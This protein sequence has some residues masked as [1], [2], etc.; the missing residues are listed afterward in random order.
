MDSEDGP[1]NFLIYKDNREVPYHTKIAFIAHDFRKWGYTV[2]EYFKSAGYLEEEKERGADLDPMARPLLLEVWAE[3]VITGKTV[4]HNRN[5]EMEVTDHHARLDRASKLMRDFV[6][7]LATLGE[8]VSPEVVYTPA[9]DA[10]TDFVNWCYSE[11]GRVRDLPK[12]SSLNLFYR[13]MRLVRIVDRKA[14]VVLP[15]HLGGEFARTDEVAV[16]FKSDI[17]SRATYLREALTDVASFFGQLIT[18]PDTHRRTL[19]VT[20]RMYTNV[21][22]LN[23]PS[24]NEPG[25]K[26]RTGFRKWSSR[27]AD[28]LRALGRK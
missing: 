17:L 6:K 20:I 25:R 11:Y 12:D 1:D 18:G 15:R 14:Q 27:M 19:R 3:K 24:A 4:I 8:S 10:P 23:L 5:S 28:K 22:D 16:T 2:K 9:K 7:A 26:G 21:S 13:F